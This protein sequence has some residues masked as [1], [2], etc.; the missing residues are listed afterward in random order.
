MQV[1]HTDFHCIGG[2]AIPKELLMIEDTSY[3]TIR[4]HWLWLF[5]KWRVIRIDRIVDISEDQK[6]VLCPV[7]LSQKVMVPSVPQVITHV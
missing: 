5:N 1:K 4:V 2:L 7:K 3:C 6:D